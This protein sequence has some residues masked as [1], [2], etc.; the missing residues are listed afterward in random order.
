MLEVLV[1]ELRVEGF[2]EFGKL[3]FALLEPAFQ[4]LFRVGLCGGVQ[5]LHQESS[6]LPSGDQLA[7]FG[8]RRLRSGQDDHAFVVAQLTEARIAQR[9]GAELF[10]GYRARVTGVQDHDHWPGVDA[11]PPS[12]EI[13]ARDRVLQQVVRL[14]AGVGLI[15]RGQAVREDVWGNTPVL[16]SGVV[17]HEIEDTLGV[18]ITMTGDEEHDSVVGCGAAELVS[19]IDFVTESGRHRTAGEQVEDGLEVGLGGGLRFDL[20]AAGVAVGVQRD[21]DDLL[22]IGLEFGAQQSARSFGAGLSFAFAACDSPPDSP[23]KSAPMIFCGCAR[24]SI[25][26]QAIS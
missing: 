23:E 20:S 9:C 16:G 22:V 14:F 15:G 19:G 5:G 24:I 17:R 2:G 18:D 7:A 21:L 4:G 12:G 26:A 13:G 6:T 8:L 25:R 11:V 10:T 3:L 1:G